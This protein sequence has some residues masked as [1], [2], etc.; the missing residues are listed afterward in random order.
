MSEATVLPT[1]QPLPLN[2]GTFKGNTWS[3]RLAALNNKLGRSPS[4][5]HIR[6]INIYT[7][8]NYSCLSRMSPN[9]SHTEIILQ[10]TNLSLVAV[11][12]AP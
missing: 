7:Q 2:V 12:L 11:G 5:P 4:L 9:Q 10:L 3:W 8:V 1:E 6:S